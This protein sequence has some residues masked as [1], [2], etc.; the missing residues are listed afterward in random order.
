MRVSLCSRKNIDVHENGIAECWKLFKSADGV[1]EQYWATNSLL[2]RTLQN[3]LIST[4]TSY[5]RDRETYPSEERAA[6]RSPV[7]ST[8]KQAAQQRRRAW[9]FTTQHLSYVAGALL[10]GEKRRRDLSRRAASLEFTF[11]WKT[12]EFQPLESGVIFVRTVTISLF[13]RFSGILQ[14]PS[15]G[16]CAIILFWELF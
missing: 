13:W 15:A 7:R 6:G 3:P 10:R 11:V 1:C 9:C 12:P 16:V 5:R 2:T 14:L 8:A 4:L